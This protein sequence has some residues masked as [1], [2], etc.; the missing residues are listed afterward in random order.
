M[1]DLCESHLTLAGLFG[2][3]NPFSRPMFQTNCLLSFHSLI[4][5][6]FIK[7]LSLYSFIY[8]TLHGKARAKFIPASSKREFKSL[9]LRRE[10]KEHVSVGQYITQETV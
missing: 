5:T 9:F 6:A 2:F 1:T 10:L 8:T 7:T 3:D 4:S